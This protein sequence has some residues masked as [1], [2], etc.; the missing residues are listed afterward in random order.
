MDILM[1]KV[2]S[3]NML[4]QA[5]CSIKP[6][7]TYNQMSECVHDISCTIVEDFIFYM[8]EAVKMLHICARSIRKQAAVN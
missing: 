2:S 7:W 8:F 5:T 1:S 3:H 4:I 6:T